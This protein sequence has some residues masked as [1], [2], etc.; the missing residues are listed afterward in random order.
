MSNTSVLETAVEYLAKE[1]AALKELV[2]QQGQ[3]IES[4][5]AW[6]VTTQ[7]VINE[8]RRVQREEAGQ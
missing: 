1:V 2:Q 5:Q 7:T 6:A 4:L 3:Q 8:F